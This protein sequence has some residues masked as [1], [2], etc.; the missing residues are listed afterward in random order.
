MRQRQTQTARV[1]GEGKQSGKW[2]CWRGLGGAKR[3]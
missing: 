3:V 2:H 1:G